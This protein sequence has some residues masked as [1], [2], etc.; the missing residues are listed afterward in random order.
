N[1]AAFTRPADGTFGT[2]AR[3]TIVGP[4]VHIVDFS[5]SKATKLTE[6]FALQFRAELFN[7]FNH[8]NLSLP[9]VDFNSGAFGSVS[10]TPDVTAGN[11]RLGEGG[12]R[13]I[14][15]G[16]KLVF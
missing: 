14:Q 10:E 15:F 13:V 7:L 16:L 9:N 5:V 6:R 1:R 8:A 12:P 4:R 11:P 2:S 3:N